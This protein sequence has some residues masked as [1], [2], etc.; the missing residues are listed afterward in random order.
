MVNACCTAPAG[1]VTVVGGTAIGESLLRLTTAPPA[2]AVPF[3]VTNADAGAPPL[4]DGENSTICLIDGGFTVI[5]ALA[6][7]VPNLAVTVDVVGTVTWPVVN[8]N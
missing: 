4:I 5:E 6:D 3:S 2:G 8:W 1:T 7:E